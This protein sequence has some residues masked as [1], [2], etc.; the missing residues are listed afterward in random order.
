MNEWMNKPNQN[1]SQNQNLNLNPTNQPTKT[2]QLANQ[3]THCGASIIAGK[4][5]NILAASAL[6][7]WITKS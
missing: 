6:A 5:V 1:Q 7:P 2:N 4:L 3:P